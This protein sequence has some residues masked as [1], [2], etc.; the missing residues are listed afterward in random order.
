[1]RLTMT[2]ERTSR[3]G[4]QLVAE[5]LRLHGV[6]T[7]FTVP[8]ES[9]LAVLDGL[10]DV[11]SDSRRGARQAGV[12]PPG[13]DPRAGAP[14]RRRIGTRLSGGPADQRGVGRIRGGGA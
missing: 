13:R 5:C 10:H 7:V 9:F 8:G 3:T 11:K 14:R 12:A 6:D 4:G 2:A 1:M